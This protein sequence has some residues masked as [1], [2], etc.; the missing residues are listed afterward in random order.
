MC[1]VIGLEDSS[2]G[3][4]IVIQRQVNKQNDVFDCS[5]RR[6]VETGNTFK[7]LY[8]VNIEQSDAG[9]YKCL[10][11]GRVPLEKSTVLNIYRKC[12]AILLSRPVDLASLPEM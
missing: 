5:C 2:Q 12:G 6:Y 3:W 8:I 1:E 10:L 7:K 11:D 9:N 4:F